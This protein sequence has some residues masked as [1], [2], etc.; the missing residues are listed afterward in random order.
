MARIGFDGLREDVS[1]TDTLR[2]IIRRVRLYLERPPIVS[3]TDGNFQDTTRIERLIVLCVSN[4]YPT[5][6][7][8]ASPAAI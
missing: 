8:V 3:F 5:L 2:T 4:G 6:G 1:D 7:L